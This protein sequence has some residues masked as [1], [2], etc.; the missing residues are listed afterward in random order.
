MKF[1]K[2]V[3]SLVIANLLSGA[4][5]AKEKIKYPRKIDL[6]GAFSW[7]SITNKVRPIGPVLDHSNGE[8]YTKVVFRKL[9]SKADKLA[10]DLYYTDGAND[11]YTYYSFLV[12]ALAVPLH[13]SRL[14]HF[15]RSYG[16]FCNNSVN[17]LTT[18][19]MT[20]KARYI[21]TKNYRDEYGD[22]GVLFPDC[23]YFEKSEDIIQAAVS[24][25]FK[26]YG[27]MQLNYYY[28]NH[29]IYPEYY[30][31]VF[32]S[33]DYGL[34]FLF[35]G[36]THKDSGTSGF[37]YVRDQIKK[38]YRS[39]SYYKRPYR[40]GK[41]SIFYS[42]IQSSWDMYNKGGKT[43]KT[44]CRFRNEPNS[45]FVKGFKR[46]LDQIVLKGN[47]PFH[48]YLPKE[49]LERKAFDEIVANFK[50]IHIKKDE[51]NENLNKLLDKT[52]NGPEISFIREGYK[53]EEPTHTV[54]RKVEFR[55]HPNATEE[56]SCGT[57]DEG[58]E[59][60]I[61][62]QRDSIL[63]VFDQ[64]EG[65]Y[66]PYAKIKIPVEASF[67]QEKNLREFIKLELKKSTANVRMNPFV[68]K[69][70]KKE[71]II[72][73]LKGNE[74]TGSVKSKKGSWSFVEFSNGK[75]GWI[76]TGTNRVKKFFKEVPISEKC[77]S[78]MRTYYI[79]L[80]DLISIDGSLE[81]K[82]GLKGLGAINTNKVEVRE[83]PSTKGKDTQERLFFGE[84][85][86]IMKEEFDV[87]GKRWFKVLSL[88]NTRKSGWVNSK[89]VE[90]K[91]VVGQ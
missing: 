74:I 90:L 20:N 39:C 63:L 44:V 41:A 68:P 25:D 82:N 71:N 9:I 48:K 50:A 35:N 36:K 31:N 43:L 83:I 2:I 45:V 54:R 24:K 70:N 12:A 91:I 61:V 42:L 85:I 87:K 46:S 69:K 55:Y 89:F 26:D 62:N 66:I 78:P 86:L 77:N 81:F 60:Q 11:N 53:K 84:D 64:E 32:N 57:L 38:R 4:V 3:S 1:K 76:F 16:S 72:F 59:V 75:E 29:T 58:S 52:Q 65:V 40:E 22:Y 79:G 88:G 14:N 33:I 23:R 67:V 30:M 5:G 37:R 56:N 7:F 17:K 27:I 80:D 73:E 6:S 10:R 49:S 18:R 34:N 21:F 51:I 15:R 13:E 19:K 28:H 47:S 8:E